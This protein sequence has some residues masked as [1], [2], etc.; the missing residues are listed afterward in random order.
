MRLR[1]TSTILAAAVLA[2]CVEHASAQ[3]PDL[4]AFRRPTTSPYLNLLDNN[5]RGIGF[6]YY[7]RVKPE[8]EFREA[9][10]RQYQS[11]RKLDRRLEQQELRLQSLNSQLGTTGHTTSFMSY[12]SYFGR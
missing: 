7:R 3:G 2:L 11:I 9:Y 1:L 12:G 6:N 8:I 5:G 4:R 10:E